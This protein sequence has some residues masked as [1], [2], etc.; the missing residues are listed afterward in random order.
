MVFAIILS[1]GTGS[2]MG[3]DVPKQ[4]INIKDRM[5]INYAEYKT[6]AVIKNC[7]MHVSL[8]RSIPGQLIQRGGIE[9]LCRQKKQ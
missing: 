4:Y 2:R 8:Y 3:L 1:D 5:L 7:L 9:K 6:T